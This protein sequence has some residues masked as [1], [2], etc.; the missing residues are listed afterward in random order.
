[1]V[2]FDAQ[3]PRRGFDTRRAR[4]IPDGLLIVERRLPVNLIW[5][6][7]SL[8]IA[9][10]ILILREHDQ[11]AYCDVWRL[12]QH[13]C[14]RLRDIFRLYVSVFFDGDLFNFGRVAKSP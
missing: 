6:T 13:E 10:Q 8:E 12:R 9:L 2:E 5:H 1:M 7:K 3:Q 14:Y 4:I 11:I